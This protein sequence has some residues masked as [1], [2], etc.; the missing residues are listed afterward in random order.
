MAWQNGCVG[1]Y[2]YI[3]QDETVDKI[4]A[5]GIDELLIRAVME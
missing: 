2:V 5:A 3:V 4:I 1:C